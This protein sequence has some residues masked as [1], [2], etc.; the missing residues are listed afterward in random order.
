MLLIMAGA[1]AITTILG[2]VIYFGT[3]DSVYH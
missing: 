3:N 2:I 1:V